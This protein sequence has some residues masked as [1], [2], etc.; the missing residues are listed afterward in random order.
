MNRKELKTKLDTIHILLTNIVQ[1]KHDGEN[2]LIQKNYEHDRIISR[3]KFLI[4][5]RVNLWMMLVIDLHKLFGGRNDNFRLKQLL[6]DTLD[7]KDEFALNEETIIEIKRKLDEINSSKTQDILQQMKIM[8]DK[9]Y[10]HL[11]LNR[12]SIH[13]ITF[14]YSEADYLIKLASDTIQLLSTRILDEMKI[15][16][17][18]DEKS[19]S[20][21]LDKIRIGE[22]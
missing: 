16:N 6:E 21:I 12:N 9:H 3:Y 5:S 15:L 4:R 22:K 14:Y 10:A 19:L 1:N 11:D 2:L 17:V 18:F 7:S 20:L 8:R 13:D